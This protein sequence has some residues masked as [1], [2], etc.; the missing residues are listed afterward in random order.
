MT[1]R[2]ISFEGGEGS[3]KTTQ[4][5]LLHKHLVSENR[6]VLLTREPGGTP[7]AEA[8]RA[9]VLTGA[10]DKWHPVSETL[11]F[12]AAR[13]EHVERV[14]KPALADGKTVLCD[15]FID[16]T[17]VYQGL[18]KQLGMDYIAALHNL[19]LGNFQPD[20]TVLLDINPAIGLERVKTRPGNELRFEGMDIGFHR[21]VRAGF[22]SLAKAAPER[23]RVVDA[24][25]DPAHVQAAIR[26]ALAV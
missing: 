13:V 17:M 19:I 21:Q 4:I 10:Q 22:L 5:R 20:V 1:G 2:F 15:R 11:L 12:L 18:G 24:S 8:I 3:G 9:L 25:G 7:S 6:P 26:N 14:I 16:S 23:F